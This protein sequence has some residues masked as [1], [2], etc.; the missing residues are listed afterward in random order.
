MSKSFHMG[1][2]VSGE[3]AWITPNVGTVDSTAE[4]FTLPTPHKYWGIQL[5]YKPYIYLTVHQKNKRLSIYGGKKRNPAVLAKAWWHFV[6]LALHGIFLHAISETSLIP[7]C[8]VFLNNV[9]ISTTSHN[10]C[11]FRTL[12]QRIWSILNGYSNN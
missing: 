5:L 1:E 11:F 12:S 6:A 2:W 10:V 7:N 9:S 3:M 8:N 4:I